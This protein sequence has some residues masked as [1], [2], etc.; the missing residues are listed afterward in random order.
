MSEVYD[1]RTSEEELRHRWGTD[2]QYYKELEA[3]MEKHRAAANIIY[4]TSLN[5]PVKAEYHFRPR[6]TYL[7]HL[8]LMLELHKAVEESKRKEEW[9]K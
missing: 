3:F 7:E 2:E 1:L 6:Q 4:D 9:D 8:Q 5:C